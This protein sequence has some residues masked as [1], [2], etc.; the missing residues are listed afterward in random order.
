MQRYS[1]FNWISVYQLCQSSGQDRRFA[2]AAKKLS[3]SPKVVKIKNVDIMQLADAHPNHEHHLCH[4][5]S[6]RNMKT[7]ARLAKDAQ[8]I[9]FIC[10][11]AAKEA[12]NLCDPIKI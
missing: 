2:M 7:A 3:D 1:L 5:L 10:G 4:I 11:R 9:C 12:K 6:L 8:Y